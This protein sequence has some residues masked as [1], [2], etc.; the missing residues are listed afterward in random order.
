MMLSMTDKPDNDPP[1]IDLLIKCL[2]MTKAEN[3]GQALVAIRKANQQLEK[4]GGSWDALLRG[5]V[6]IIGDPFRD[7][8][9]PPP[10]RDNGFASTRGFGAPAAPPRPQPAAPPPRPKPRPIPNKFE[11]FCHKCG[12]RVLAGAG[13]AV[14][15]SMDQSTGK[16]K[17][18]TEHLIGECAK[19]KPR[20]DNLA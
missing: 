10:P 17:W 13:L 4:F 15:L 1:N 16:V 9:A 3:D 14:C 2:G 20:L 7:I 18:G 5:K 12:G 19:R 6:T 11:G 8:P